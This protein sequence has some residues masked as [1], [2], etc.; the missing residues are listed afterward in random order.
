[1]TQRDDVGNFYIADK[2]A[3]AIR[4]VALWMNIDANLVITENDRDFVRV[5]CRD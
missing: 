3:H 1:M 2:D 5:V 4:R